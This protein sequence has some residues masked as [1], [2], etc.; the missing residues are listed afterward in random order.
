HPAAG[1]TLPGLV[2]SGYP[3]PRGHHPRPPPASTPAPWLPSPPTPATPSRSLGRCS[4]PAPTSPTRSWRMWPCRC[5]TLSGHTPHLRP[6]SPS[7]A[8][9]DKS[10]APKAP[11]LCLLL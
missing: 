5:T 6:P 9:F 3:P 7:P 2:D 8:Q 10:S 4:A 1:V 11:H